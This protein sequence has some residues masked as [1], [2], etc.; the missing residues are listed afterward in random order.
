[1][2]LALGQI[3]VEQKELSHR[4]CEARSEQ[5]NTAQIGDEFTDPIGQELQ[6]RI[7]LNA[8]ARQGGVQI[9]LDGLVSDVAC[10]VEYLLAK[11]VELV[12]EMAYFVSE[13]R[14]K[15]GIVSTSCRKLEK[16]EWRWQ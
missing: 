3:T 10:D 16:T 4:Q 15:K 12:Y 2:R 14:M 6:G 9:L 7:N 5:V 11:A 1:M 8:V 13:N